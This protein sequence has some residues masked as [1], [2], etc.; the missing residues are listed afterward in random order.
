MTVGYKMKLILTWCS[1][2]AN[3]EIVQVAKSLTRCP[4][5]PLRV[6][7]QFLLQHSYYCSQWP[8]R[9]CDSGTRALR[10]WNVV[11]QTNNALQ[12][13]ELSAKNTDRKKTSIIILYL[14]Q[15][16]PATESGAPVKSIRLAVNSN[17]FEKS[18]FWREGLN[19][20]WPHRWLLWLCAL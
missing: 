17:R 8:R 12:N 9:L 2:I 16:P 19:P 4:P 14:H 3:S 18:Y 10:L 7:F 15:L 5:S 13:I 11:R 1:L 20:S 6:F